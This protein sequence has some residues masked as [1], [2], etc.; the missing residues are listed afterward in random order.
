MHI[1][2]WI[3][4]AEQQFAKREALE[5]EDRLYNWGQAADR[6]R[7]LASALNSQGLQRNDPIA[8]LGTNSSFYYEAIYGIP[9][10]GGIMVPRISAGRCRSTCTRCRIPTPRRC[11]ST[12]ALRKSRS[13]SRPRT[14]LSLIHISEPTRP[15]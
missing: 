13:R 4:R 5:F 12:A 7:R 3:F 10:M 1:T 15:Y 9:L 6:V 8:I 14:H 11:C 2:Q